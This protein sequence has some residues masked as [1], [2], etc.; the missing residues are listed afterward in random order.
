VSRF[1]KRTDLDSERPAYRPRPRAEFARALADDIRTSHRATSPRLR[2]AFA[3]GLTLTMLVALAA[4]GGFG[5]AANGVKVQAKAVKAVFIWKKSPRKVNPYAHTPAH[6]Q[7][8]GMKCMIRHRTG[9][10]EFII[11]EV[12]GEAVPAHQAHGDT[13]ISCRPR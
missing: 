9:N 3:A 5:Y 2:L 13:V 6:N 8:R 10:G 1:W 7:Y 4:F 12:A 11:I